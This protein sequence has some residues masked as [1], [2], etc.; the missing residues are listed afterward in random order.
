MITAIEAKKIS[1]KFNEVYPD[2]EKTRWMQ[3]VDAEIQKAL[4]DGKYS[5][6]VPCPRFNDW[7]DFYTDK[8][9]NVYTVG[10]SS[11]TVSWNNA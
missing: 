11:V 4:V 5:A 3:N 10:F 7:L 8:G 9:Y 2:Y 6:S 1:D